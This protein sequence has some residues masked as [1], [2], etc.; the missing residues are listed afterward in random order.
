MIKDI[1]SILKR[2]LKSFFITPVAYIYIAIFIIATMSLTFYF[3]QYFESGIADLSILFGYMPWLFMFFIPAVTMKSWSEE[4]RMGT[5]ELLM[6][7]PIPLWKIVFGKFLATWIFVTFAIILT[8]PLWI[9]TNYLG[10]PDNILI[11]GIYIGSILMAGGYISIG[12]FF[13]SLTDNQIIAFIISITISFIFTI[14]GFS[15]IINFMSSFLPLEL[16]ELISNFSF[17]SHF[18]AIQSGYFSVNS[19]I[20]FLTFMLLWNVLTILKLSDN[21]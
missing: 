18:T 16:I 14:A 3:G 6:T 9:T 21:S 4:K 19:I 17:L 5:I 13:S 20:F 7:L 15:L 11:F 10:D 8:F 2:E 12:I 1:N